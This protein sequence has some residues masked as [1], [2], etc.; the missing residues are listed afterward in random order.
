LDPHQ[1]HLQANTKSIPRPCLWC[2]LCKRNEEPPITS[3]E[4]RVWFQDKNKDEMG[5]DIHPEEKRQYRI[6]EC[7]SVDDNEAVNS[8]SMLG[9]TY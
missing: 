4:A 8:A 6:G 5:Y 9:H 1:P 2:A 7:D 3:S